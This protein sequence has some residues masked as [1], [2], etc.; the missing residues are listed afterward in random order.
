MLFLRTPRQKKVSKW[1]ELLAR[2]IAADKLPAPVREY[3]FHAGRRWRLDFVWLEQALA[4]EVEGG[5]FSGGR[6]TRGAGFAAD[7]DKYNAAVLLGWRL[8]R[9]TDRQV[10]DGSAVAT[11]R[12]ALAWSGELPMFAL[13]EG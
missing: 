6:H 3:R 8:L 4:V 9:F 13:K 11:I 5:I 7:S 10:K 1:E 2:Q 12:A